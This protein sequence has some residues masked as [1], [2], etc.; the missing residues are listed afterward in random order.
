MLSEIEQIVLGG[1]VA[2]DLLSL[3]K[4]SK[5]WIITISP[6]YNHKERKSFKFANVQ[7]RYE[8]D[9]TNEEDLLEYPLPIIGFDSKRLPR[10]NWSFCLNAADIEWGFFSDWPENV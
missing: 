8:Q 10:G 7:E 4:N 3:E 6:A 5:T 1:D 2:H 9:L